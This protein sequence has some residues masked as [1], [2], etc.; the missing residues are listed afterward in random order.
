MAPPSSGPIGV[1]M[2]LWGAVLLAHLGGDL[3]VASVVG[4]V[5]AVIHIAWGFS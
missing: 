3:V 1:A 5:Y 4:T 2:G